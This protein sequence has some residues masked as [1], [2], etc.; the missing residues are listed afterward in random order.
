MAHNGKY[1]ARIYRPHHI[2]QKR[3]LAGKLIGCTETVFAM[4]VDAVTFGGIRLSERNVRDLSNEPNPDP[5]SPGL[6][7]TQ[8]SAIA[9]KIHMPGYVNRTNKGDTWADVRA[10]LN[11]NRRVQASILI[12]GTQT[13][14]SI[15]LQAV[16]ARPGGVAGEEVLINNPLDTKERWVTD[17]WVANAMKAFQNKNGGSGLWYAYSKKLKYYA[18]GAS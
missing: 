4:L 14:H 9:I 10:R 6:N 2:Q 16:R 13:N 12:P 15:L 11:E 7:L 5:A 1:P 3:T 17:D 18:V 8:M